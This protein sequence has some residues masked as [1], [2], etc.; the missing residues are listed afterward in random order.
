MT[1]FP[2]KN[3]NEL[4]EFSVKPQKNRMIKERL[5]KRSVKT[6]TDGSFQW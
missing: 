5:E 2:D 6:D 4:F 1:A 3:Y